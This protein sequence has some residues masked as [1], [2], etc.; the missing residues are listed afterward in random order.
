[1]KKIIV[2]D[3]REIVRRQPCKTVLVPQKPYNSLQTIFVEK[4]IISCTVVELVFDGSLSFHRN[5]II[6]LGDISLPSNT[7]SL[8][9]LSCGKCTIIYIFTKYMVYASY[10]LTYFYSA[11]SSDVE[12]SFFAYK[13]RICIFLEPHRV[14]LYIISISVRLRCV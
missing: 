9:P 1:M 7:I 3:R 10:D 14:T 6:P 2:V 4:T 13:K 5:I 11:I 12:R 8:A